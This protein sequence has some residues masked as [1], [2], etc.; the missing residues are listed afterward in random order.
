[1][2]S[3]SLAVKHM[4]E[5]LTRIEDQ[6]DHLKHQKAALTI[7]KP[8]EMEDIM[9]YVRYFLEHLEELLLQQSNSVLKATYFSLIFDKIPTF[10]DLVSGTPE[11]KKASG[12]S[13]LF[14]AQLN[15]EV[16]MAGDE[17]FEPPIVE[18]ESTALPL[19]QSPIILADEKNCNR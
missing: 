14:L 6:L 15:F 13:E 19:G 3:S 2:L 18:P 11:N 5:E 1:M 16:F 7:N 10:A 12:V 8:V 4:E 17:G 9:K